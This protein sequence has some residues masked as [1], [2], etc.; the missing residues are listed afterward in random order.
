MP[1]ATPNHARGS[2]IRKARVVAAWA[3]LAVVL[4]PALLPGRALAHATLQRSTPA[5]HAQLSAAPD[6]VDLYFAQQLTQNRTGTFAVVLDGAGRRVSNEAQ[7]DPADGTH[8]TVPLH[9]GLDN[10]VYTVF[11]KT[12]S[13]DD[14]GVT[15][16]NFAF[17]LGAVDPQ[18]VAA[19]PAGGQVFVPDS[20]R[21]RALSEPALHGGA[22]FPPLA[23]GGIG[24]A[25]GAAVGATAVY[26]ARRRRSPTPAAPGSRRAGSGRR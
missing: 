10:G 21:S 12:T 9:G 5:D 16:G 7:I 26:L 23:A 25:A 14:G 4:I 8:M 2:L 3:V 18:T 6:R 15:L 22:G 13:D 20:D 24:A 17:F 11:W 1:V 19:T